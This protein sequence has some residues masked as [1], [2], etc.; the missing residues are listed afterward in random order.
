MKDIINDLKKCD[1]WKVHLAI[2]NNF[3]S[4]IDNERVKSDN[5]EIMIND[6]VDEFIKGLFYSLKN[7]S[8]NNLESMKNIHLLCYK[9]HEINL[10]CGGS[11]TDSPDWIKSK[12]QQQIPS[13]KKVTNAFNTL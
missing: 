6:K 2:A 1:T 4:S 13:I 9:C 3:I 8:Q 11:Y 5:I 12:K 7:R 10:N